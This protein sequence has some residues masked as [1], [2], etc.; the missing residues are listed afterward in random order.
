MYFHMY[1]CTSRR[2]KLCSGSFLKGTRLD[3]S[4]PKAAVYPRGAEER[5]L[6]GCREA[7]GPGLGHLQ[8]FRGPKR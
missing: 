4:R 2:T 7:G 1:L 5:C 8:L 3:L 6:P